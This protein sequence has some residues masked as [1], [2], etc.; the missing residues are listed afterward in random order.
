MSGQQAEWGKRLSGQTTKG[1]IWLRR[2]L[3]EV[4]WAAIHHRDTSFRARY[5]RL[6][7]RLGSQQAVV[8]VMHHLLVVVYHVLAEGVPYRELGPAYYQPPHAKRRAARLVKQLQQLGYS[9]T[10][11]STEAA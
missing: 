6:K 11:N 7:P 10:I 8:A 5:Y 2:I 3:G 1:D 9:V 4:A